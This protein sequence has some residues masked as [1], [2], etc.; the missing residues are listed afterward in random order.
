MSLLI[1]FAVLFALFAAVIAYKWN[2]FHNSRFEVIHTDNT[3]IELYNPVR[4]QTVR[5]TLLAMMEEPFSTQLLERRFHKQT[6][7][8]R[9]LMLYGESPVSFGRG[10]TFIPANARRVKVEAS[11]TPNAIFLRLVYEQQ[12]GDRSFRIYINHVFTLTGR[13]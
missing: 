8:E 10:S 11:A 13:Q 7:N 12:D 9:S 6:R 5:L 2:R 4:K 1:T 3:H